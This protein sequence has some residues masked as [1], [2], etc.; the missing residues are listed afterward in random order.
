MALVKT[1]AVI[2]STVPQGESSKIVRL[3]TAKFGRV[4]LIAKGSRAWKNRFGGMLESLNRVTVGYNHKE[5]R[6]LHILSQCDLV[7]AYGE[8]K[9]D[10]DR[11][12]S[13]LSVLET[14]QY[15]YPGEGEDREMYDLVTV[16]LESIASAERHILNVFWK[17]QLE[18]LRYAGF[19]L[20]FSR[21]RDCGSEFEK[22][23]VWFTRNRGGFI[24]GSCRD[25]DFGSTVSIAAA[26]ALMYINNKEINNLSS[27]AVA[28][29]AADEINSLFNG[30]FKFHIEGYQQPRSLK[31]MIKEG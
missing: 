24:C 30:Y 25:E 20:D 4:S 10:L 12:A 2:L 11:L 23:S 19:G 8:I 28:P 18:F 3:F 6:D 29:V 16:A 14:I 1:E 7:N 15:N 31:L 21:C 17:F 5:N 13:G 22:G 26:K 27:L 9:S